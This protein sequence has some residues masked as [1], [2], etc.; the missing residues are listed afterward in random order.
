MTPQAQRSG[1]P[2][3]KTIRAMLLPIILALLFVGWGLLHT[4][5][6]KW[7]WDETVV[8]LSAREV[9][10]GTSLYDPMWW[11][12]PPLFFW[13]L[14]LA[15][16]LF[17]ATITVA[18][19]MAVL[20]GAVA[21]IVTAA[22]AARTGSS[23]ATVTTALLLLLMPGFV[24]KARAAMLDVPTVALAMMALWAGLHE[25][26]RWSVLAGAA[27]AL[28][29]LTKVSAAPL[30]GALLVALVFGHDRRT[31]GI[32]IAGALAGGSIVAAI[33]L[34][35]VPLQPFF[36]QVVVFNLTQGSSGP[37]SPAT[38]M[39]AIWSFL[40][41]WQALPIPM[42]IILAGIGVVPILRSREY[43]QIGVVMLTAVLVQLAIFLVYTPLYTHLIVTIIPPMAVLAGIGAAWLID[44]MGVVVSNGGRSSGRIVTALAGLALL[45]LVYRPDVTYARLARPQEDDKAHD[46]R[47]LAQELRERLPADAAVLSDDPMINF[48]AGISPPAELTNVA[49]RR[50]EGSNDALF[51][52]LEEQPPDVVI[53]WTDRFLEIP[54]LLEWVQQRYE[55]V[56]THGE[57]GKRRIYRRLPAPAFSQEVQLSDRAALHGYALNTLAVPAG[58]TVTITPTVELRRAGMENL[59]MYVH[60]DG[61]AERVGSQD[62][63]LYLPQFVRAG[64]RVRRPITVTVDAGTDAGWYELHLGTYNPATN[65]YGRD[66]TLTRPL[67]VGDTEA[68]FSEPSLQYTTAAVWGEAARLLGGDVSVGEQ[69]IDVR[70]YWKALQHTNVPAKVFVHLV[71]EDGAIVAQSDSVPGGGT[72][73]LSGWVRE[74]IVAD[75]H[76]II[77]PAALDAGAYS[78]VV[79]MYNADTS[80]RLPARTPDEALPVNSVQLAI[81]QLP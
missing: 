76:T 40:T 13:Q 23:A 10:G 31:A 81:V 7:G 55:L 14:G 42:L 53:F 1:L 5:G 78:L 61:E 64:D 59:A 79:G 56:R 62:T 2:V 44:T 68:L 50:F 27:F 74:E 75:P 21:V 17:G 80:Q 3:D 35:L 22:I 54:G 66:V 57:E 41:K 25:S 24:E 38:N 43:R 72:R 71:S 30:A 48:L 32:R 29:L 51:A 18:R 70:L 52:V 6:Y 33:V 9:A 20:W 73:P 11:N 19:T 16:D 65:E 46:G 39:I 12:Y 58:E 63:R 69:R 49:G 77:M 8:M 37:M 36:R 28:A 34:S 47:Q 15:F 4:A 67:R 45:V 26:R 60:V